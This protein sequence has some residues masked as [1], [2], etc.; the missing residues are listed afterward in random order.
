MDKLEQLHIPPIS[1]YD[2][3]LQV[4]WFI[5]REVIKKKTKKG[6][7]FYIVQ[8]IDSNSELRSIKCWG[9]NPEKDRIF[10]NRPYMAKLDWSPQWGFSS[11][12]FRKTFKL[13]A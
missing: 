8:V 6:K 4:A 12:A 10:I 13:L 11:R 7:D 9:V 3:M 2:R 1:E 5:P